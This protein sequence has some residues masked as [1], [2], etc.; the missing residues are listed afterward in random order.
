MTQRG[1]A[2]LDLRLVPRVVGTVAIGQPS[3]L[4]LRYLS[5]R[6]LAYD[7]IVDARSKVNWGNRRLPVRIR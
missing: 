4:G 6:N 1:A 2:A 7:I 5:G 3:N